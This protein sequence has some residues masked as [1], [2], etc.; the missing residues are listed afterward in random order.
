M[1]NMLFVIL[2]FAKVHDRIIM[3]L[4]FGCM[5]EMSVL[6]EFVDMVKPIF[7]AYHNCQYQQHSSKLIFSLWGMQNSDIIKCD[8]DNDEEILHYKIWFQSSGWQY[9][10]IL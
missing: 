9:Q 10:G 3:S 6:F 5:L 4:K 8:R 1:T 7:Q 2:N